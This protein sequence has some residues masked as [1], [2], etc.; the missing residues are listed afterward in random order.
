M[1]ATP[2][3]NKNAVRRFN[4][5]VIES[6]LTH[7]IAELVDPDFVNHAAPPGMDPG[8]GGMLHTFNNVLRPALA[9]MRVEI[10]DQVAEGAKVTTR[11]R[12]T[13]THSGELLGI[14]ATGKYVS[15]DV[16]DMVTLRD[17]RYLE[18]WGVNTLAAV[19]AGLRNA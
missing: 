3:A 11:K 6:G 9:D 14:P 13:G 8:I 7:T 18:H 19:L 5:D 4:H 10:L 17:G 16:I 12:I 2:D 1:T 15:I